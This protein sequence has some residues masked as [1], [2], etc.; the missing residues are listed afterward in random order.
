MRVFALLLG[1]AI[2]IL[3]TIPVF[4]F[5]FAP[6]SAS[7]LGAQRVLQWRSRSRSRLLLGIMA[8]LPISF[9]GLVEPCLL[10]LL[11]VFCPGADTEN[12]MSF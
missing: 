3:P 6:S 5:A 10:L 2:P 11:A 1:L 8:D 9:L 7:L 4:F 12:P